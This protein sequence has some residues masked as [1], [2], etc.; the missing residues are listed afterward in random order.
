M[1]LRSRKEADSKASNVIK[2][3]IDKYEY[4]YD[5]LTLKVYDEENNEYTLKQIFERPFDTESRLIFFNNELNK[6]ISIT[7]NKLKQIQD[8]NERLVEILSQ[9]VRELNEKVEKL[10]NEISI[11]ENKTKYL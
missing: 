8:N 5:L 4:W 6:K 2:I 1:N 10:E 11:L 9:T 7:N 3:K